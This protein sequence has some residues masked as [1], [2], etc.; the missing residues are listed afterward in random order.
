MMSAIYHL[1][2]ING[3]GISHNRVLFNLFKF[4]VNKLTYYIKTNENIDIFEKTI[5]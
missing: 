2:K 1:R 3:F 5:R 4:F